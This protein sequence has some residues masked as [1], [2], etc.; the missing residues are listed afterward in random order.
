M[1][2]DI[3]IMRDIL[4][5]VENATIGDID[6]SPWK[7]F[8]LP[9]ISSLV[10]KYHVRLLLER[11]YFFSEAIILDGQDHAGCP[12][13]KFRPDA[14]NDAGHEFLESIR[15]PDV[16]QKTKEGANRIGSFGIDLIKNL[17]KGYLKTK[18]KNL[19]GVEIDD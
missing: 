13:A 6:Q 12:V 18:I 17:A 11:D 9:E 4:F 7:E 19:T 10:V 14:L 16:W 2:R 15:D 5:Q 1:K 8:S 3:D